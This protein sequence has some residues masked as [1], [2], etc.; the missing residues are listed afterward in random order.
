VRASTIEEVRLA[1]PEQ[2]RRRAF[3]GKSALFARDLGQ[4]LD[5]AVRL[6]AEGLQADVTRVLEPVEGSDLLRVVAGQGG[7]REALQTLE[8][9]PQQVPLVALAMRSERPVRSRDMRRDSRFNNTVML[10]DGMSC[11]LATVIR[12][13]QTR[14]GV[15]AA[16]RRTSR[17]FDKRAIE[18][19]QQ[20]ANLLA[21]AIGRSIAEAKLAESEQ[22]YRRIADNAPD[23]IY[24][25]RLQ[26]DRAYE[27]V[28]PA[29]LTL[30]GYKPEELYAD[31]TIGM[32]HIP[33]EDRETLAALT[34]NQQ[35]WPNPTTVAFRRKDGRNIWLEL[36]NN[37]FRNSEGGLVAVEG[38]ARDITARVQEERLNQIELA[39]D[40]AILAGTSATQVLRRLVQDVRLM[41]EADH[42]SYLVPAD[43]PDSIRVEVADGLYADQ[44]GRLVSV[45]GLALERALRDG[46]P[47]VTGSLRDGE[48]VQLL[49]DASVGS[50][51]M[52]PVRT[53]AGGGGV[54]VVA[55]QPGQPVLGD[56]D[57]EVLGRIGR[58]A[59]VAIEYRRAHDELQRVAVLDDRARIARDLHD[60]IIQSL[61][62]A[63]M[64]LNQVREELQHPPNITRAQL[65]RLE[66]LIGSSIEDLRRYVRDLT[67]PALLNSD[68]GSVVRQ[69]VRDFQERTGIRC[70]VSLDPRA[71]ATVQGGAVDI[72]Q[73]IRESLSNVARHAA[74]S[75]CAIKLRRDG[76]RTTLEIRDDGRGLQRGLRRG[77]GL[78]NIVSRARFLGG[79]AAVTGEPGA[80]TVVRVIL[81]R[82]DKVSLPDTKIVS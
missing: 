6:V 9:T 33:P 59:A 10:L 16:Y 42:A 58:R 7:S 75:D 81:P 54:L 31:P 40:E 38:I 80:G 74:A 55:S 18:F 46:E 17:K 24:R 30:T 37:Y 82:L 52:M 12:D 34:K 1:I 32:T 43:G 67:P 60:G 2:R 19:I 25:M 56:T 48:A 23:I 47:V 36:R 69:L 73:I 14:F 41:T 72:V 78:K 11:G 8:Y 68:L 53:T 21:F 79:E 15:L 29:T 63:S 5:E 70:R 77:F 76:E 27:Y 20:V 35:R 22:R 71:L 65:V 26:P 51:I 44:E 49:P 64:V 13:G 3:F 62:A 39:V 50:A 4:L 28:S 61:F 57:L 45:A 66:R